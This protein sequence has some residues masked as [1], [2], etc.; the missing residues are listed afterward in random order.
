MMLQKAI[1]SI[2]FSVFIISQKIFVIR[3]SAV[4]CNLYITE[5]P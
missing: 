4:V 3:D 5:R 1:Y 2:Q